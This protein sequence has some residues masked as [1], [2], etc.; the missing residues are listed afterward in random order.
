MKTKMKHSWLLCLLVFCSCNSWIDI[1]PSDRLSEDMLFENR[2]GFEKAINGVYVGLVDRSLYGRD[3]SAG[4]VDFM[5]QYYKYG[6]GT[7]QNSLIGSYS[8]EYDK[9]KG[10]FQDVW[11]KAYALI[12]NCNIIIEKCDEK[13]DVLPDIY[14][15]IYKG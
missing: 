15:K 10:I 2:Q 8:Y 14:R 13:G 4:V 7:D 12:V 11:E 9:I 6:S 1:T 3:L 5:A